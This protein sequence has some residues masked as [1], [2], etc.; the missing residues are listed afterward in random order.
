MRRIEGAVAAEK[1]FLNTAALGSE[2]VPKG[3][4][5]GKVLQFDDAQRQ[6]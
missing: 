5:E 4:V 2:E 3:V 1:Q 6:F